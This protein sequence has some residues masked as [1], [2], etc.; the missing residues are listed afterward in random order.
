MDVGSG[1]GELRP[2]QLCETSGRVYHVH[3]HAGDVEKTVGYGSTGVA[4]CGYNDLYG[5]SLLARVVTYDAGEES[6]AYILERKSGAVEEFECIYIVVKP[7][8]RYVERE[9]VIYNLLDLLRFDVLTQKEIG[10]HVGDLTNVHLP[11]IVEKGPGDHRDSF[12]HKKTAVGSEALHHGLFE[13]G[14][15]TLSVCAVELHDSLSELQTKVLNFDITNKYSVSH[16]R[17]SC[18]RVSELALIYLVKPRS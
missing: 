15:L 18:V 7:G 16:S 17:S 1:Y 11:D 10:H 4:G 6:C 3:L 9:G 5:A 8:E 14:R 13:R 2:L 12:R